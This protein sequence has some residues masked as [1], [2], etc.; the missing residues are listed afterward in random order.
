MIHLFELIKSAILRRKFKTN[1]FPKEAL[2]Y[3]KYTCE[4][5]LQAMERTRL[6]IMIVTI[7]MNPAIDKTIEIDELKIGDLNRIKKVEIDAGGKGINVSKTIFELGGESLATGF[8]AGNAGKT[9]EN[10]LNSTGIKTDFIWVEGETRT[11]TKVFESSGTLTELNEAGVVIPRE[12]LEELKEKIRALAGKDTLFVLAGSIPAG[13]DKNIYTEFINIAHEKGATVLL[14]ADGDV[15]RNAVEAVPDIIK[16]NDHELAEYFG[17][18]KLMG[19]D[20]TIEAAA[21]FVE[22]GIS[23]VAVTLGKDGAILVKGDYKV[24]SEAVPV[25]KHSTVG[26]GDAFVAGL[27]YAWDKKMSD[28]DTMKL[29]MAVSAGAVSTIGTKPPTRELVEEL[30]KKVELK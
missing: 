2:L 29:C 24:K 17:I 4:L 21:K 14:D 16:P 23:T 13:V 11:N 8:L 12:K 28:E 22:K 5:I 10:V 27:A 3:K 1:P 26:A 19:A 9:I 15:F 20:E 25:K 6:L 7:T 18:D 30:I